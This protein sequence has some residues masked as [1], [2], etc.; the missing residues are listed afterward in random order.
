MQYAPENWYVVGRLPS[1][2]GSFR[3]I[4]RGY[5]GNTL[6]QCTTPISR[7]N[8]KPFW[9]RSNFGQIKQL[10]IAEFPGVWEV[11]LASSSGKKNIIKT[12]DDKYHQKNE[13]SNIHW[14]D[15]SYACWASQDVTPF[16]PRILQWSLDI[17]AGGR[18]SSC[19]TVKILL[20]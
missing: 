6:C 4:F 8:G 15:E 5:E 11:A 12:R 20:V 14:Q 9:K 7:W 19:E 3:P 18:I 2:S 10:L 1:F 13:V 17:F 16:P